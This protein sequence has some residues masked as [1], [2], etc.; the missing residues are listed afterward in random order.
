MQLAPSEVQLNL[1]R[2][3]SV[4]C[5]EAMAYQTVTELLSKMTKG[6]SSINLGL[7]LY[8]MDTNWDHVEEAERSCSSQSQPNFK[9]TGTIMHRVQLIATLSSR[10]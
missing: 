1:R 10:H 6:V 9:S 8:A 2:L 5:L 7:E 4:S 3:R